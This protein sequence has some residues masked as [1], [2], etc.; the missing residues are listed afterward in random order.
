MGKVA[1]EGQSRRDYGLEA[2]TK[3]AFINTVVGGLYIILEVFCSLGESG[4]GGGKQMAR[5]TSREGAQPDES[6]GVRGQG[7]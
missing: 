6:R 7:L 2:N 1:K 4:K 3:P 5:S